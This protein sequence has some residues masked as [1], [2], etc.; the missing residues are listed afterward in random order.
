MIYLDNAATSFPKPR[1]VIEETMRCMRF[2]CGNAGRGSHQLALAAAERIYECRLQIARLFDFPSPERVCFTL[3]ATAAINSA[4]KGIL[5]QGDHVLIS[6]M[7]HNA[8]LRP[9]HKLCEE[10]VISYDVFPSFAGM[11]DKGETQIT[12]AI[13]RLIRPNTRMLICTHAS[14]VCSFSFPIASIGRLC[15]KK[16]VLFMVD[17]AQSAGHL[18]I[19]MEQMEIDVLCAPS[20]KG[21]LGP[22]GCGVLLLRDDIPCN[23]LVEGGSGYQSL[24]LEMPTDYPERMEAGTLPTPAIVGL[25][26]GAR[27]VSEI[28]VEEILRH[29][30]RLYDRLL[31]RITSLPD[32][33]VLAPQER[34]PVLSF[35][36]T[37]RT[38]DE[39]GR[40]LDQRGICA[41]TGFHCAA[42]PHKTL[43]TPES[44]AVRVSTGVFNT[45]ADIDALYLAL[46]EI[47]ST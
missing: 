30:T 18:P 27:T 3:N 29:E 35:Y 6:D 17:A 4:I 14:N 13:A 26:V 10:G 16:G 15:R 11:S 8:V 21:L 7:E 22:Q 24:L 5:K 34:G 23:T 39:I 41:R 37:H 12:T 28:G 2:Y 32:T 25:S 42:L 19:S 43:G 31:E 44:G 47:L 45:D 46:R 9:I 36:S 1:S 40:A 33:F 38:A 20:H